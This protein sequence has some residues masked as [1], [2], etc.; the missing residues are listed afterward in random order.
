[1]VTKD[2]DFRHSH[3]VA[4]T[5]ASLLLVSTGNIRNAELIELFKRRLG[6][7]EAAFADAAFVELHR[8]VLIVYADGPRA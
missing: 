2:A 7:V 6:D 8:D 3:T 1:M 5:P 4:G